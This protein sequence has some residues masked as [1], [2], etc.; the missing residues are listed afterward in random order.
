MIYTPPEER[1]ELSCKCSFKLLHFLCK[2]TGSGQPVL[3]T[4]KRP[5]LANE[6]ASKRM[7]TKR[8]REIMTLALNIRKVY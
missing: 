2:L 3:T 8:Q 7:A 5:Q 1:E 6:M 4:G